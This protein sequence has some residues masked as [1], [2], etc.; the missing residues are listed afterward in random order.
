MMHQVHSLIKA[1]NELYKSGDAAEYGT[2][3]SALRR[4]IKSIKFNH[5]Q[6]I[7]KHF[8][9]FQRVWEGIR[10]ITDYEGI[11]SSSVNSCASLTKEMNYFYARFDM[12]N[13]DQMLQPL[14]SKD[15]ALILRPHEVRPCL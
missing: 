6:Q 4:G 5:K 9:Y 15:T 7:E 13:K 11:T 8:N 3:R 14:S 2:A 12:D 10:A 1:R